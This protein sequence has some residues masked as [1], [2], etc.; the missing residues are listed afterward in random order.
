ML[1]NLFFLNTQCKLHGTNKLAT[2]NC[3]LEF[4][5]CGNEHK[6]ILHNKK[7]SFLIAFLVFKKKLKIHKNLQKL[8]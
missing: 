4:S 5:T 3:F 2:L 1:A 7:K 6:T 8:I